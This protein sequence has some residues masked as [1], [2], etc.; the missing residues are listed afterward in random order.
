MALLVPFGLREGQLYEPHQ[1][2]NG[3]D[4]G[5]ICP[6]CKHPLVAKQNAQTPHFAHASGENCKNGL[7]TAIHFA[8]KQLVAERMEIA[9][10]EVNLQ[11]P[12]GFGE[13]PSQQHLYISTLRP[14][15][16]VRIEPWL[17]GFRPDLI[18][19]DFP[20][21]QGS[22]NFAPP[23]EI[24]IEIAVTHFVD[25]AKRAQIKERNLHAI[26]IDV[27][28]ARDKMDFALLKTF[29]FNV[30]SPAVWIHHPKAAE[31]EQEYIEH[32]E[33]KWII[34]EKMESNRF[35][36][37]RDLNPREQI[38]KNLSKAGMGTQQLKAL[39]AFVAGE[40]SFP[41][42]REAWQSAV[43]VY[44]SKAIEEYDARVQPLKWVYFEDMV[45]WLGKI[46]EV[47]VAF[48]DAEKVA[49]WK[50]LKHL[51]TLGLVKLLHHQIF[52]VIKHPKDFKPTG[53]L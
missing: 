6:G 25:E 32:R 40:K 43:L 18:V 38:R 1:G 17:D 46:F 29:L 27:S 15:S 31:L 53:L 7:E 35:K 52:E 41:A 19:V 49:A 10:P 36:S 44:L 14:L 20:Q 48:P 4:C 39:T 30:P 12:R 23:R 26:E 45:E 51:E 11:I 21:S 3:K 28:E 5:C 9:L 37:Y 47:K 50:Y 13:R 2:A 34:K 42:G 16:E 33:L 8:A 24:L 22:I